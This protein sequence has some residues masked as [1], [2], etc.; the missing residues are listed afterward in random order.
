VPPCRNPCRL[1]ALD[2]TTMEWLSRHTG[3]H[4]CHSPGVVARRAGRSSGRLPRRGDRSSVCPDSPI[5]AAEHT[6]DHTCHSPRVVARRAGRSLP[7]ARPHRTA[8]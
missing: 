1:Q 2:S 6:G 7:G 3:Y 8:Q 5:L 4:T